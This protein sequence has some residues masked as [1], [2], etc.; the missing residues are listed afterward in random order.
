MCLES[1]TREGRYS[2]NFPIRRVDIELKDSSNVIR[3]FNSLDNA[4]EPFSIIETV[5]GRRPQPGGR[6]MP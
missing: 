4:T 2:E 1:W 3:S 5:Q 6:G